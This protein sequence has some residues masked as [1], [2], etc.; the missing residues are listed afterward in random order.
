VTICSPKVKPEAMVGAVVSLAERGI[1][2]L[3]YDVGGKVR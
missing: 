2:G 1:A 3:V